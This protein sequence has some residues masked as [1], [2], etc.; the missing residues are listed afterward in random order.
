V[1]SQNLSQFLITVDHALRVLAEARTPEQ[2]IDLANTA[3]TLR[4]YAQRAR[5]GNGG[6]ERNVQNSGFEQNA[7]SAIVAGPSEKCSAGEHFAEADAIF[8]VKVER[9]ELR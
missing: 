5:L 7:N 2:L 6:T 8:N 4:R 9:D 3:E 1:G